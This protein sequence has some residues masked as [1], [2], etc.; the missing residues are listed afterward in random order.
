MHQRRSKL[1][2]NPR[3]LDQ[4]DYQLNQCEWY[5]MYWRS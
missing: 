1:I 5:D 4:A 2:Q 3:I